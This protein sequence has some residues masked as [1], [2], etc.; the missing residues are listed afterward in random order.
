MS[1]YQNWECGF[2]LKLDWLISRHIQYRFNSN[3]IFFVKNM[4]SQFIDW[5]IDESNDWLFHQLVTA[6][7]LFKRQWRRGCSSGVLPRG[8]GVLQNLSLKNWLLR[9]MMIIY[10]PV[11]FP[12]KR[13]W[14]QRYIPRAAKTPLP[15]HQNAKCLYCGHELLDTEWL[16]NWLID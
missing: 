9:F 10:C 12:I 2:G 16:M 4:R 14:L 3:L 13:H 15:S 5:L 11:S 6:Y 1:L 8:R 7:T